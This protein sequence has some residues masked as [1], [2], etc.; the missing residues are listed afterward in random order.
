MARVNV[1]TKGVFVKLFGKEA[2]TPPFVEF[3]TS[4]NPEKPSNQL[5]AYLKMYKEFVRVHSASL[6]RMAIIEELIMQLRSKENM[7][8]IK[9]ALVRGYIYARC[10]IYRNDK[11]A[12]DVRVIIDSKENWKKFSL[13]KLIENEEFMALTYE[14]LAIHMDKL[15][16]LNYERLGEIEKVI[17]SNEGSD[18]VQ[19]ETPKAKAPAKP[20]AESKAKPKSESKAKPKAEPKTSTRLKASKTVKVV[21]IP[22]EVENDSEAEVE[23]A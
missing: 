2:T 1:Q 3:M 19:K 13:K 11:P 8:D 15:I 21:V 7:Q 23:P 14:R 12:K 20:K 17:D 4:N 6:K 10:S 5:K 22:D 18:V 16:E 9:L